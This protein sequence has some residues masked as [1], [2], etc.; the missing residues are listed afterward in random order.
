MLLSK[1]TFTKVITYPEVCKFSHL[2]E[3]MLIRSRFYGHP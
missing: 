2:L 1:A 3:F